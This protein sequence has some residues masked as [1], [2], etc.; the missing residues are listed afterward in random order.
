[1]T[2]MLRNRSQRR[3]LDVK[4]VD[5][6]SHRAYTGDDLQVECDGR[7][8]LPAEVRRRGA[9][10]AMAWA[11]DHCPRIRAAIDADRRRN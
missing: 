5:R 4:I 9:R 11:A 8:D 3:P 7:H 2:D 10:A 6:V 1:M